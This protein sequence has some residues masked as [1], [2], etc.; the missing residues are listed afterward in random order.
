MKTT[1]P[2]TPPLTPAPPP[3]ITSA[4]DL[5]THLQT[6][7]EIEHSDDRSLDRR[8][9]RERG[10]QEAGRD[11][12][13]ANATADAVSPLEYD[14]L[15]PGLREQRRRD[16]SVVAASNDNDVGHCRMAGWQNCRKEVGKARLSCNPSCNPAIL[17]FC[18]LIG[19][20]RGCV[21]RSFSRAPP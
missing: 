13:R 11:L 3:P 15:Q 16:Q 20:V 8:R 17:P 12:A 4:D 18:N 19:S 9:V 10:T 14:H 1:S 5:K 21:A 7:L 6:A 2:S